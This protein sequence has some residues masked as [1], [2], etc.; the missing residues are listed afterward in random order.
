M[1]M[2]C[3]IGVMTMQTTNIEIDIGISSDD[4]DDPWWWLTLTDDEQM[5]VMTINQ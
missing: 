4:D 1:A 3:D 5:K 2:A